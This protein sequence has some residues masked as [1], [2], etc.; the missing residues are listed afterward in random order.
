MLGTLVSL[1]YDA[2]VRVAWR[3]V[4]AMGVVAARL[5]D[6]EPGAVRELLRRLMWLITE[7]SGAICWRAP[8]AMAEIVARCPDSFGDY[9]PIVVHLLLETAEEDLAHFRAGI[10]WAIGRLGPLAAPLVDEVLPAVRAALDHPDAQVRAMAVWCLGRIGRADVLVDRAELTSDEGG[11]DVYED[12]LLRR[13]TV[14]RL[15]ETALASRGSRPG[16]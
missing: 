11:A 12:G 14:A 16:R 2:D 10:L 13:T 6:E 8:E 5:A 4:E 7:E 15:T 3:A 9:V 1:T